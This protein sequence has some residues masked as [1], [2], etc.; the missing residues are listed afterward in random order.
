ME[1]FAISIGCPFYGTKSEF[2]IKA[3]REM[4]RIQ[5]DGRNLRQLCRPN[6]P[7]AGEY[8]ADALAMQG[9]MHHS[10]CQIRA[11]RI[12]AGLGNASAT[13][14]APCRIDD[15]AVPSGQTD[16]KSGEIVAFR[17]RKEFRNVAVENFQTALA[18]G[19]RIIAK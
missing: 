17:F 15:D 14:D 1:S 5:I 4:A 12:R 10:P 11:M 13:D 18:I 3:F 8:S 9:S 2:L 7:F 16:K 19:R 6:E